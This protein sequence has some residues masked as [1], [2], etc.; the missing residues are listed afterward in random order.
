M[1]KLKQYKLHEIIENVKEDYLLNVIEE[2][3]NDAEVLKTKKFLNE[4]ASIV[5]NM[6]LEEGIKDIYGNVKDMF[7]AYT[8]AMKEG[9]GAFGQGIK[10]A[11]NPNSYE[12][13]VFR[14][15]I[16]DKVEGVSEK[17][18]NFVRPKMNTKEKI[19]YF[20][21]TNPYAKKARQAF[22]NTKANINIGL[23]NALNFTEKKLNQLT[24]GK[25]NQL[26]PAQKQAVLV[27]L[28]LGGAGLVGAAGYGAY[29]A[30]TPDDTITDQ[31]VDKLEDLQNTIS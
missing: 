10:D 3:T 5:E 20:M 17:L 11:F 1:D 24:G 29:E 19:N 21:D 14:N 25:Y 2:S 30:L 18:A 15:Q 12:N 23:N 8:N 6:I 7:G 9:L 27:S 22:A 13:K 16:A 4:T 31:I 28:G 26:T